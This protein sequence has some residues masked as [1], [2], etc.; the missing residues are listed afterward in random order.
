MCGNC[1]KLN[2]KLWFFREIDSSYL[3]EHFRS[4]SVLAYDI[5]KTWQLWLSH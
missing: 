2:K 5:R 3:E 1:R 4:W